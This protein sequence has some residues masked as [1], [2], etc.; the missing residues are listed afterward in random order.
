MQILE[1]QRAWMY[2]VYMYLS[3]VCVLYLVVV[4]DGRRNSSRAG[5]Y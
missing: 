2:R 4:V 3:V 1:L 5:G